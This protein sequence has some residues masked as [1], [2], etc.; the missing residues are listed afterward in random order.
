MA[1]EDKSEAGTERKACTLT[2]ETIA[3]LER[4]S[5]KGTHGKGISKVMTT[6]I[7]QGVR[8]AIREGFIKQTDDD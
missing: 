2:V 4:L 6:L 5:R 3:Y 8:N 1:H 7:E